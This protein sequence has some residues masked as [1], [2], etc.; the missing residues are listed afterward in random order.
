[1]ARSSWR[2]AR[3]ERS[4]SF[5][6]RTGTGELRRCLGHVRFRHRPSADQSEFT[7]HVGLGNGFLGFRRLP[8][9]DPAPHSDRDQR[10]QCAITPKRDLAPPDSTVGPDH[11]HFLEPCR[12]SANRF[13][14]NLQSRQSPL[15]VCRPDGCKSCRVLSVLLKGPQRSAKVLLRG[16]RPFAAEYGSPLN[17]TQQLGA[18]FYSIRQRPIVGDRAFFVKR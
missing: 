12:V 4:P 11:S 6:Q 14:R 9:K 10:K 17:L 7:R 16:F 5:N 18:E 8:E 15:T 1:M 13:V 3:L 2:D